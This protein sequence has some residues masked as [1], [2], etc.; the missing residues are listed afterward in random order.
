MRVLLDGWQLVYGPLSGA[1]FHVLEILEALRTDVELILAL[2][3]ERPH[4]LAEEVE[5][6]E[7]KRPFSAL[8]HLRWVQVDLPRIARQVKAELIHSVQ[9]AAPLFATQALFYSPTEA[10]ERRRQRNTLWERL[11]EA[12]GWGGVSRAVFIEREDIFAEADARVGSE[13]EENLTG[14]AFSCL[15]GEVGSLPQA[16][17]FLYQSFGD[18]DRLQVLLQVWSKTAAHLGDQ[19]SLA[20]ICATV[21]EYK[22]IE[23]RSST[24]FLQSLRL[25]TKVTPT[26]WMALLRGAIALIQLEEEPLWGGVARRAIGQGVPVVGF[27]SPSLD[28]AVGQA[29]YLVPEGDQR[30]LA[31]ALMTLVVEEEVLQN[32]QRKAQQ[33]ARRGSR[34]IFRA[35]LLRL[36]QQTALQKA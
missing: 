11:D 26:Q 5:I 8:G 34:D 1:A 12:L 29:A 2:P 22:K 18:W 20:I 33:Q 25:Y 17:Y 24:E 21:D 23:A 14:W 16:P 15:I 3:A 36:Y 7:L 31:A 6:F 32:L 30:T 4:W 27:E 9:A 28:D 10:S 13:R 19:A 35:G